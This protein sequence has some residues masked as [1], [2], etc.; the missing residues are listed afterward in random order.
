ME[1]VINEQSA[2][3]VA[4]LVPRRTA[5]QPPTALSYSPFLCVFAIVAYIAYAKVFP[6]LTGNDSREASGSIPSTHTKRATSCPPSATS[7]SW[8]S[9]ISERTAAI[10]F[11]L[12][13][14]LAAV[15]A[16]LIFCE[17]ADV[18]NSG[19]RKGGLESTIT[20]L[21]VSLVLVIPALEIH[22]LT[23]A[24]GFVGKE[25][26]KWLIGLCM[27]LAGLA[28]WLTGFWSM[29][30][31]LLES[32][33]ASAG[34]SD[35]DS[36]SAWNFYRRYLTMHKTQH[37]FTQGSLERI[38]IIGIS[39]MAVLA[40]FA[41]ISSIWQSFGAK[42]R[43]VSD[44]DISRKQAG[45]EATADLLSTKESRLRALERRLSFAGPQDKSLTSRLLGSFRPNPETQEL[46]ALQMEVSGLETMHSQLSSS[47]SLLKSR[48]SQQRAATTA[49]GRLWITTSYLFSLYCIYRI[50]A[51]SFATFRRYWYP[52]ATFA[53]T[54]P[55]TNSL[56]LVAKIWDPSLD[57]AAWSRQIAFLLSGVML[58]ASFN[59][60]LQTVLLFSRFA[61]QKV[62]L[63]AKRGTFALLVA[64]ICATYVVSSA[65]LLRTN[66]P[67]E[68]GSAIEGALGA[69]LDVGVCE[70][71]FEG[72]FLGS[73]GVTAAGVWVSKR[74]GSSGMEWDDDY[75]LEGDGDI[76]GGK[77]I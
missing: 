46:L 14:A 33:H 42:S 51:T 11:T 40:G 60:V 3:N 77:R 64:Q 1:T 6:V 50:L 72:W 34:S 7:K 73:C 54:D 31:V 37:G 45:L 55:I 57:R 67:R 25:K 32:T 61:P 53:S 30:R 9:L 56:A 24:I 28:L 19:A 17:I 65:L 38:G 59:A 5:E 20:A 43:K 21:L 74:L 66:L 26:G 68:M 58:L 8:I 10:V 27:D 41:S 16:Q 63:S 29:G 18:F 13:I 75:D 22:S 62:L 36:A 52:S 4:A 23:S 12:T 69:P 2:P 39:L 44:T 76:E 35:V 70:R 71:M 48:L 15:L 47:L 49:I